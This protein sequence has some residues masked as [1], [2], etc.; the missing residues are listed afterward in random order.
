MLQGH[1]S[2]AAGPA[3]ATVTGS[4]CSGCCAGLLSAAVAAAQS[5]NSMQ[6]Q[7]DQC[8]RSMQVHAGRCCLVL[9]VHA[10]CLGGPD[11]IHQGLRARHTLGRLQQQHTHTQHNHM[12]QTVSGAALQTLLFALTPT[13]VR[14]LVY[15]QHMRHTQFRPYSWEAVHTAQGSTSG[16][17]NGHSPAPSAAA[18][19]WAQRAPLPLPVQHPVQP[20]RALGCAAQPAAAATEAVGGCRRRE[21]SDTHTHSIVRTVSNVFN[22]SHLC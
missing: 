13:L 10:G 15:M 20:H 6:I 8:C 19:E 7:A 18:A 5:C 12:G 9:Q 14:K 22:S 1:P 21:T 17:S 4:C 2:L 3:V 16:M 11:L